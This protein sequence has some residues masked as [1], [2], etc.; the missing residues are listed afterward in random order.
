MGFAPP[1]GAVAVKA[2]VLEVL[3]VG[4]PIAGGDAV[5][6]RGNGF[7]GTTGVTGVKF[8]TV[9]ATDYNVINDSTISAI[10]PAG[11]AGAKEVIVTNASGVASTLGDTYLYS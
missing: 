5:Y 9:N 4:G 1:P 6:I 11:T 3:P 8:G 2:A 10:S 7:S